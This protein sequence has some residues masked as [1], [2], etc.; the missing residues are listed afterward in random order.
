MITKAELP[1]TTGAVAT[2][3]VETPTLIKIANA[4]S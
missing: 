3:T 2:T 4:G 1:V